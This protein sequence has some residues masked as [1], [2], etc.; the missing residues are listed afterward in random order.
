VALA[1][2]RV[3]WSTRGL[4]DPFVVVP[5][6][7]P[8]LVAAFS[9]VGGD[10]VLTTTNVASLSCLALL[11]PATVTPPPLSQSLDRVSARDVLS[12]VS[13][14]VDLYNASTAGVTFTGLSASAAQL[15][16]S[17]A[18]T[19]ECT[20]VPTSERLRL[21]TISLSTVRLTLDWVQ[22][23]STVL[24]YTV[25]PLR[26]AVVVSVPATTA[27]T[28]T[29][30]A[31]QC[32]LSLVNATS[33][34]AQLVADTWALCI[35]ATFPAGT[36]VETATNVTV[37]APQATVLFVR[38]SCS[39]WG[40]VLLSPPLRLATA[41]LELRQASVPPTSFIASDASSSLPLEPA[42]V[43]AVAVTDASGASIMNATDVTCS[44]ST[45]TPAA[46]LKVVGSST[47]SP[48]LSMSAQPDTGAVAVP[49]FYVQT[50][51]ITPAV[52][53]VVECRRP[54][55]D[56]PP[57]L[58]FTIPAV[59]LSAHLC[60]QPA[61][62]TLVSAP[63][64][65]FSVGIVAVTPLD[66][67]QTAPCSASLS[68]GPVLPPIVCSIAL[69]TS[70]TTTND[71]ANI[72]LQ[73]TLA[74]A[75]AA[76]HRAVFDSF[77]LVAPQGERYG[78][79]LTCAIGG[80][81]ILP[82]LSFTVTLQGCLA[83]Q[84]SQGVACVTCGGTTFSLGGMGARCRGCP[85]AGA[86]CNDG[87]LS[88]LPY[89]FRPAAQAGMPLGP[90]TELHPCANAEACTL[91]YSGN[92]SGAAYGCAYGYTGPLCGVCD[93]TV[94]YARF[95]EAC[96]VCWDTG[97]SWL[98]LLVVVTLVLAVLTRVALRKESNRSDA[99]IVLRITLGYLQAVGSLRVFR[100]G[101]TKAYNSV[102]GWT[103]VV[104]ASPLGVGALQCILRLP[105]LVQYVAT[106]ALPVLASAAVMAIFHGV[107]TGRSVHCR[108]RCGMD[109]VAFRTAV[110]SWWASKRHLSTLLFVLFLAYMPIVSASLRALDC[111]D[112][113]A[114]VRYLRS[115]LRVE[116]S[117]GEHAAARALAYTVLVV[118]GV[119]FPAGLAWL[120]GTARND[121]LADAGF[122]AIWGFL[123]DGY[124]A[125]T[126][127]LVPPP[128]STGGDNA[129]VGSIRKL[130]GARGSSVVITGN[131]L[132]AT[133][134]KDSG[135]PQGGR[136]RSSMLPQ[137]LSQSWV[138]SGDSRVWW[139]AVVLCRKAGV[140]LLAVTLTDPYLQCAG[141]SLWFAGAVALQVRYAPYVKPWH[142]MLELATLVATFLTAVITT[143]LLQYNVGVT[144]AELHAPE[145]MTGLEW[146]VTVALAV[147]N[148][149]TFSIL[150][151]LWLR[152]QCSRARGIVSRLSL[153]AAVSRGVAGLRMSLSRR[154]SR[155]AV[156]RPSNA[157]DADAAASVINPLRVRASIVGT[158]KAVVLQVPAPEA[159]AG[160]A[161]RACP[162]TPAVTT[163]AI[164]A[165]AATP[166]SGTMRPAR[167]S[168]A[169]LSRVAFTALPAASHSRRL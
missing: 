40:Q 65:S 25:V 120:L 47:S 148:V 48:L 90:D 33:R 55:G 76:S 151:G 137:R 64:S 16:Q 9:L 71:T 107:T 29:A 53:V 149:G 73:N 19:A 85:P 35:N 38:A 109:K 88:L 122:R 144:S 152:L 30:A 21:P 139:E 6:L 7:L 39:A 68:P 95:G 141:A 159:A 57:P 84:E 79:S 140:V 87:V 28:A 80:L 128:P 52:E 116:C 92:A 75:S 126:R 164:D 134:G 10:S 70:A 129:H 50:A 11:L 77:T 121:Q 105:Y 142:N 2:W 136:R 98:F 34:S 56:A 106:I 104:S 112:P 46:E 132:V 101:S 156:A 97:A 168:A 119:G 110:A 113:V 127:T 111:I 158:G 23:P 49:H 18:L 165:T 86:V 166:S 123:F 154:S 12:T 83:G 145:A 67:L 161:K 99:A 103:E 63:L 42:L 91:M 69:D 89:Y 102:M 124:R 62:Y 37:Q 36:K 58:H 167:G 61:A 146:A 114:G 131:K 15:G 4:P 26:L 24:G 13:G 20:W 155:A 78:L 96:A 82:S 60:T 17:L 32:E 3:N 100:A 150:V 130:F 157:G 27:S 162:A 41:K 22:P 44:L 43:V 72:F 115:D 94:N 133:G 8:E 169:L 59:L 81:A 153:G 66:G 74:A 160:D 135:A 45:A 118:V 14:A 147:L 93:A 31:A 138:V 143:I 117:V 108:P 1:A 163:A 51:S 54:S 5:K 125:P